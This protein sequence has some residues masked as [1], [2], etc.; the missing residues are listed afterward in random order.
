MKLG[1]LSARTIRGYGGAAGIVSKTTASCLMELLALFLEDFPRLRDA[2]HHAV[3]Q[4]TEP[5]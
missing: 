3:M 1:A 4:A 2:L 5:D